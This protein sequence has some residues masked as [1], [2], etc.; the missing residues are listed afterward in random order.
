MIEMCVQVLY[1]PDQ[2]EI[3]RSAPKS[4]PPNFN[5]SSSNHFA[6]SIDSQ[7]TLRSSSVSN[8]LPET[9]TPSAPVLEDSKTADVFE[10]EGAEKGEGADLVSP[11]STNSQGFFE[12]VADTHIVLLSKY[13][14]DDQV[15]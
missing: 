2:D 5:L 4:A 1:I 9:S 13:I 11:S 8:P 3:A 10:K 15:W 14:S 6:G 7:D 12:E